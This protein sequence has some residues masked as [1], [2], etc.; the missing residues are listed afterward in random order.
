M[1]PEGRRKVSAPAARSHD[2]KRPG[3]GQLRPGRAYASKR[4]PRF[5]R[6]SSVLTV[7][8]YSPATPR[9]A[10]RAAPAATSGSARWSAPSPRSRAGRRRCRRLRP[11]P[12]RRSAREGTT[13]TEARAAARPSAASCH[14]RPLS[15]K[16][17]R[18][19]LQA[20]SCTVITRGLPASGAGAAKETEW[21]T[22]L[23]RPTLTKPEIPRPGH[24]AG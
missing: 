7:S 12:P 6:G 20:T 14:R 5:L 11:G 15:R 22:S 16:C 24:R 9:R 4:R 21:T 19:D 3:L 8:R 17:L 13:M 1:A 23:R 10:S 2:Q 18:H